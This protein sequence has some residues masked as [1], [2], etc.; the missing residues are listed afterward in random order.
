MKALTF[1][2]SACSLGEG[3]LWHPLRNQLFW[4]DINNKRLHT[5][6]DDAAHHWQFD[7]PVSAAGWIDNSTLMIASA[8]GLLNFDIDTGQHQRIAA[9]EADRPQTRSNDGRADPFGGFWIGTMGRA[10][11]PRAG[12]IYRYYRGEIRKLFD[13]ITIPN[14]ICFAPDGLTAYFTDTRR[15]LIQRQRLAPKDG[16]PKGPPEPFLDCTTHGLNPDGAVVAADGTLWVAQWGAYRVAAYGPDGQFLRAVSFPAEQISCPAFGGPDLQT[17]FATS[18]TE[19]L[20]PDALSAQP[21]AG[22]T[23]AYQLHS[24]GQAEHQVIL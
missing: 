8:T 4:F 24:P 2:E 21:E 23:F 17:L 22:K 13:Q 16:W 1:D 6:I 18:A 20:S 10:A 12:A 14:A 3:L 9:L 7:E 15:G 5:R 19:G 11:E